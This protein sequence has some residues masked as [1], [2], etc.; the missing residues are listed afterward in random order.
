MNFIEKDVT[1]PQIFVGLDPLL[2]ERTL[3]CCLRGFMWVSSFL[4]FLTMIPFFKK[5]EISNKIKYTAYQM[6]MF[7]IL[8]RIS[9]FP[10]RF[11]A[12][13][14]I[15]MKRL[16][17]YRFVVYVNTFNFKIS[18]CDFYQN[19]RPCLHAGC[20]CTDFAPTS[21]PPWWSPCFSS[22]GD[23]NTIRQH[24]A[25]IKRYALPRIRRRRGTTWFESTWL[26]T[27]C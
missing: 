14:V 2:C 13:C 23:V 21:P 19:N 20:E 22:A 11:H 5:N 26:E 8:N 17:L 24:L 25:H 12:M 4:R 18:P 1:S 3:Q 15:K 7:S 6:E 9:Q 10:D 27:T 16:Q